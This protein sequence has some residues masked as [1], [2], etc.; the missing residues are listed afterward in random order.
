[1]SDQNK[2]LKVRLALSA[3]GATVARMRELASGLRQEAV[4][5]ERVADD[6]AGHLEAAAQAGDNA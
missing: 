1:M 2:E 3:A 5:L 6:L 4:R